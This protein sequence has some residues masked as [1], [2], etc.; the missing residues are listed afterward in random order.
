MS[1][2]VLPLPQCHV[3]GYVLVGV[4]KTIIVEQQLQ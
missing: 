3:L 1:A 4:H 2:L